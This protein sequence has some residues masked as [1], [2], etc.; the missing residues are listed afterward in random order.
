[1]DYNQFRAEVGLF[2]E[3]RRHN[4][5]DLKFCMDLIGRCEALGIPL[6][7]KALLAAAEERL[8]LEGLFVALSDKVLGHLGGDAP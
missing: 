1:M 4:P 5:D 8:G 2:A 6:D 7:A 3:G